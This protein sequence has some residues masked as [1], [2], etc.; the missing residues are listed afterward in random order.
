MIK[1]CKGKDLDNIPQSK[2]VDNGWILSTKYDGNYVQIQK[3]GDVVKFFTSGEKE[4]YIPEI[5]NEL[6]KLNTDNSFTIECEY[7][8]TSDGK[9]GDRTKACKLTTYRTNFEKG[10]PTRFD[11]KERFKAFDIIVPSMRFQDRLNILSTLNLGNF[12][13]KVEFSSICT[14]VQSV[15]KARDLANDGYEV[16]YIKHINHIYEPG[17]R[18]NTAAKLKYRKSADLLC[19]DIIQGTGKYEGLIGSL[20]LQ[21]SKGRIV[22][23][24]SGLD[25]SLRN[26]NKDYFLSKVIEVEYEQII[27]TYIQPTYI[28]IRNDKTSKDID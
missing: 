18:V 23:V 20:V 12:I 11:T 13:E 25:D 26:K 14:V 1:Q 9:L 6:I 5:A 10:L 4:F 24:G 16:A 27:D 21:D 15:I 8:G 19:I 2:L 3:V 22:A 7:I 17:K 28:G